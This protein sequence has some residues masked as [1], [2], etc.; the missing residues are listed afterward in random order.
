MP[1]DE[2]PTTVPVAALHSVVHSYLSI[3]QAMADTVAEACPA[4][5]GPTRQKLGR[6]RARLAF[7][8]SPA[9]LEET[10]EIAAQEL[11]N[12]SG[13]ARTYVDRHR[14]ELRRAAAKVAEIART[15]AHRQDFYGERLRRFAAQIEAPGFEETKGSLDSGNALH[16]AGLVSCVESM[17]HESQSLLKRIHE[18]MQAVEARL[19]EA[20]VTDPVTGLMNRREMERSIAALRSE[21]AVP[22]LLLFDFDMPLPDEAAQ[23]AATRL[24]SQF[25]YSDMVCRWTDRQFL[26]LFN[27]APEIARARIDQVVPWVAGRYLLADGTSVELQAGASLIE[28]GELDALE[29]AAQD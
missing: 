23:Q 5:G 15:L 10:S 27:G 8:S 2:S 20:E 25:R 1:E 16:A 9:A 24:T 28:D 19:A 22:V 11:R 6:L 12:Y 13:R 3:V 29:L 18:E 7:D 21:G 26:V 17:S 4:V 14:V